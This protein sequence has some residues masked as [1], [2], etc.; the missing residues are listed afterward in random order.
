MENSHR[1]PCAAYADVAVGRAEAG[2]AAQALGM[3]SDIELLIFDGTTPLPSLPEDARMVGL[4]AVLSAIPVT[5]AL[6]ASLTADAADRDAIRPGWML[7]ASVSGLAQRMSA[8]RW[9]LYVAAETFGGPGA[10][11]AVGWLHGGW[12][13]VRLAHATFPRTWS[14]ATGLRRALTAPLTSV[15]GSWASMPQMALTSSP[16]RDSACTDSHR[17]GTHSRQ[18]P[19]RL[20]HARRLLKTGVGRVVWHHERDANGNGAWRGCALARSA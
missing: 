7:R 8:D 4:P 16:Q 13:T 20:V 19:S 1:S 18:S 14:R 2:P 11:E 5:P 12:R 10:Q 17:T 3:A 15:S 9:V 6:V